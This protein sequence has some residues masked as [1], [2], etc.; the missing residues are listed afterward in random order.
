MASGRQIDPSARRAVLAIAAGRSAIGAGALLATRPALRALGFP[1]L[2]ASG[3]ALAHL[4]GGRDLALAALTFAAR[5]DRAALRAVTL[6]S[7]AVDATDAVSLGI[8]GSRH[9]ELRLAGI[10]GVLSGGSAALAGAW[11]WRRLRPP[12][13]AGRH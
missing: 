4:A 5:R 13:S 10:G 2:N 1:E 11:A 7:V 6:A 12:Q 3:A 8:A 9:R